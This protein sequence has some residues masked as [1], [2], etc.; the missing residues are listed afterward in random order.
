[1]SYEGQEYENAIAIIGMS[2]RFPKC[3]NLE[4]YWKLISEGKEGITFF[5][6]EELEKHGVS[7]KE[8]S[9]PNYV[10][11]GALLEGYEKFDND[12]FEVNPR[13]AELM[14]PQQRIFLQA[15]YEVLEDAG[16]C[17][18]KTDSV[19]GVYGGSSMNS[20]LIHNLLSNR[21]FVD[22]HEALQHIFIHG[23][24]NDYLCTRVSYKLNLKGPAMSVQSA[25]S[26]SAT[27]TYLACQALLNFDCDIALAGGVSIRVPQFAGYS[28]V[29]GGIFSTNGHCRAF[30]NN[31]DGTI[32]GNGVG[33]I[34]LKRLDEAIKYDDNIIAIIRGVGLN[35]DGNLKVGYSAPSVEGQ[36]DA[37][38]QAI[39][40][41]EV[42]PE[43]IGYVEM[44]GTGTKLGDVIEIKAIDNAFKQYTDKTGYC[45]IGSVKANIGHLNAASGVASIIKT[46]LIVNKGMIP[47]AAAFETPNKEI[48]FEET[49]FYVNEKLA[50]WD[51]KKR[52]AG[53][54]SFGI[55]GTNVHFIIENYNADYLEDVNDKNYLFPVS[56]KTEYSALKN[57]ENLAEFMEK[58]E[59]A[60]LNDVSKTLIWGRKS[61][62]YR[63]GIS[64]SSREEL[65]K[66]IRTRVNNNDVSLSNSSKKIA[67]MF[68]GQ[69]IQYPGMLKGLYDNSSFI[70]AKADECFGYLDSKVDF[71]VDK[72]KFF[73]SGTNNTEI[74]QPVLFIWE[75][76]IALY[77][78]QIGIRPSIVLGHSLGEYTAACIAGVFTFEEAITIL[79]QRGKIAND[80][81][82]GRMLSVS[83]SSDEIKRFLTHEISLSVVNSDTDCV[84]SGSIEAIDVLKSSLA[85]SD[86]H[87][88]ELRNT[89]AFHSHLFDNYFEDFRNYIDTFEFNN[90][91]IKLLSNV[92]GD[93]VNPGELSSGEYW[94][95]HLCQTVRFN[96]CV[97]KLAKEEYLLVIEIGTNML[98][99]IIKVNIKGQNVLSF[100]KGFKDDSDDVT[101]L[102]NVIS[103]LWESGESVGFDW[104]INDLGYSSKYHK[105]SLPTYAF[106]CNT[107]CLGEIR[108]EED[109]EEA[110][111]T[112]SRKGISS[113]YAA[114][115]N[116]IQE[117]CVHIWSDILGVQ[118]IGIDDD[119][120]ELGGHSLIATQVLTEIREM[121][122]VSIKLSKLSEEPTIRVLSN[123]IVE[124]LV[125]KIG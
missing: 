101:Y 11:A 80:S 25:C 98:E 12:F 106:D 31:S 55:G 3:K 38:L 86:I 102:Y 17:T 33:V 104:I 103:K 93:Y 81:K 68:P 6:D 119:F 50:K 13:E 16:Y 75:Y 5:T 116:E 35:N 99:K 57:A 82:E 32:F 88:V 29:D 47:P 42:N 63:I 78:E 73:E 72:Y 52:I 122:G 37:I 112:S 74:V 120:F 26:T 87:Y 113:E 91:R 58:A 46:A 115:E 22:K 54:S 117:E 97:K 96:S 21:E 110:Q 34:A 1:M 20:F 53:V 49:P 65:I 59:D 71:E 24:M 77:L 79:I 108:P 61:Y 89:R 14:D 94:A 70:K 36:R 95:K 9:A 69:G 60:K 64:A 18:D 40:F 84:V 4:D 92:T 7:E 30:D 111:V 51:D 45:P 105:T 125:E 83:L 85:E 10:K 23:N 27:A 123:L 19:I 8:Y 15:C 56:G 100:V 124:N 39:D 41:S 28:V 43:K 109:E 67:F 48:K 121:F 90:P 2:G 66:K 44:H 107:F 118:N 62:G 114:P 76:V